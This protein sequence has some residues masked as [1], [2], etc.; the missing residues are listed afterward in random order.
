MLLR[1]LLLSSVGFVASQTCN[2]Y[3]TSCTQQNVKEFV[4]VRRGGGLIAPDGS[5]FNFSSFNIPN[6]HR[7]EEEDG[8][9]VGNAREPTEW[10]IA[11]ALCSVQQVHRSP[12][13]TVHCC[14]RSMRSVVLA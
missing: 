11:D 4:R 6:L 12:Q 3:G 7:I 10:E 8:S 1:T 2:M 13:P 14:M 5:V 9:I